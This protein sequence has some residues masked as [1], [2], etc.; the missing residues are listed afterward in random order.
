MWLFQRVLVYRILLKQEQSKT[1]EDTR[2]TLFYALITF[3]FLEFL[4]NLT[5]YVMFGIVIVFFR[6]FIVKLEALQSLSP[7]ERADLTLKK[8][9]FTLTLCFIIFMMIDNIAYGFMGPVI[10]IDAVFH[11]K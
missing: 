5:L 10:M 6:R 8:R 11:K 9:I 7:V 1:L 4:L 3:E 2:S